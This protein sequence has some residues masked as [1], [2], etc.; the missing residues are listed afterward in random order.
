MRSRINSATRH[1]T[2]PP[3]LVPVSTTSF[4]SS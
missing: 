2:M 1:A 3:E 4:R